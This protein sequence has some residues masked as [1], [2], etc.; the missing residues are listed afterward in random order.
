MR[1]RDW[2]TDVDLDMVMDKDIARYT[3]GYIHAIKLESIGAQIHES[4]LI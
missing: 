3:Y 2:S 4:K 1:N